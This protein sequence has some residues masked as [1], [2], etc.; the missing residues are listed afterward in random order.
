MPL[1][2]QNY[3]ASYLLDISI[4]IALQISYAP[5]WMSHLY[6]F[7]QTTYSLFSLQWRKRWCQ[8]SLSC[9]G[10]CQAGPHP[11]ADA[12]AR[13]YWIHLLNISWIHLFISLSQLLL[14]SN[15]F[16]F[17]FFF[18]KII[19]CVQVVAPGKFHRLKVHHPVHITF[20]FFFFFWRCA[21]AV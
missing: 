14:N 2:T 5:S 17:F 1:A 13:S 8:T 7:P 21:L 10:A 16:F 20:F 19:L 3:I 15:L 18:F 4:F 6:V 9:S 12:G 11:R